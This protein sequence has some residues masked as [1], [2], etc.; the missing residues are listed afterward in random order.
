MLWGGNSTTATTSSAQGF[1]YLTW[2]G[3]TVTATRTTSS[4][5]TC[6]ATGSMV[7]ATSNLVTSV[8]HG[9]IAITTGVSNTATITSVTTA[10]SSVNILGHAQSNTNFDFEVNNP[11]VVLTSATVVTAT[12]AALTT[13][14]VVSYQVVNWNH[15]ALNQNTQPFT[16]SWT[17][18]A[19]TTTQTITSVNTANAM[20]LWGGNNNGNTATSAIDEQRGQITGATTVTITC[21]VADSDAI[22]YA[23]T[24]VEFVSGVLTQT[25]QRNA[26]TIAAAATSGTTTITSAATANS[27]LNLTGWA[28]TGTAT[29]SLAATM[30]STVQTNATTVTAT[31]GAAVAASKAVSSGWEVLTFSATGGSSAV[32]CVPTSSQRA[33]LIY[34]IYSDPPSGIYSGLITLMASN[35]NV[36]VVVILNPNSGPGSSASAAY[37]TAIGQLQAAGAVVLGYVETGYGIQNHDFTPQNETTIKADVSSWVSFYPAI[38]GIFFDEMDDT[39]SSSGCTAIS[40]GNCITLYQQLTSFAHGLGLPLTY[41]NP[42]ENTVSAYFAASPI[43]V[44]RF[45]VFETNAYGAATDINN[46]GLCSYFNCASVEFAVSYSAPALTTMMQNG[47]W[48]F[49][50]DAAVANPYN[51]APTYL[52]TEMAAIQAFNVGSG[53]GSC[54]M[55]LSFP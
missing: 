28:A 5:N 39:A 6:T 54:S 55:V 50:T 45:M 52:S 43:T 26:T 48:V 25:A 40:G 31:T 38:Q 46:G 3:T 18:S 1:C 23:A 4:T 16:K 36:P 35:P 44:D 41:G 21:G 47:G 51:V 9:T 12:I 10:D 49:M 7:D 42:G 2:S 29:T 13:S 33:G 8:Q 30:P 20:L 27:A 37:T 19:T 11:I 22:K 15:A 32:Q 53:S 34:P 17:N 14:T 24:V